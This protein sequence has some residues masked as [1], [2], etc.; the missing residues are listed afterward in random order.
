MILVNAGLRKTWDQKQK[1]RQERKEL[2]EKVN[3]LKEQL[4]D[5]V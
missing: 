1:L 2:K 4:D 3:H 5:E